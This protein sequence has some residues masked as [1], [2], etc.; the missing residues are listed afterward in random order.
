MDHDL[1]KHGSEGQENCKAVT[2]SKEEGLVFFFY[3]FILGCKNCYELRGR[4]HRTGS[5]SA[6]THITVVGDIMC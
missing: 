3:L 2:K 5:L 1:V 4:S 6:F